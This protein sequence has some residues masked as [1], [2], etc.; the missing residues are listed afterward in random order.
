MDVKDLRN[1][2]G[3][4]A[5]GVTVVTWNDDEGNKR[6]ITCNSFTTVSLD[7]PLVLVSIDKHTK[8]YS[9]LHDRPFVVNV[10]ASNQMAHAWQ[11]AGKP[12]DGLDIEWKEDSAMGPRL[13][14]TVSAIE[15]APW[16]RF[17]AGDHVLFLGEVKDYNYTGNE[18]LLFHKGRFLVTG[19]DSLESL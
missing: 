17:D 4:F 8:A 13:E 1:C 9:E 12:Q 10:L 19:N 11:F 2:F 3:H 15:C 14:H 5:T 6:G 18:S 16:E 7:P